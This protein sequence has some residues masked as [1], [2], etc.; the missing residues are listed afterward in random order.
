[1]TGDLASVVKVEKRRAAVMEE[2][3]LSRGKPTVQVIDRYRW[4]P[5]KISTNH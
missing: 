2:A 5:I 4:R 1:M 3:G